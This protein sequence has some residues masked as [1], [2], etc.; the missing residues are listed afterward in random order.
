VGA[1]TAFAREIVAELVEYRELLRQIVIRDLLVRYKQTVMGVGWALFM[2]LLNTV[3]F[4]VVFMRVTTVETPVPYPLF[5]FSGLW[6][7]NFF[8]SALRFSVTSLTSNSNLV[9]KVYFPREILPLSTV[10]ISFVDFAVGSIVL[11][12]LMAWYG[13]TPGI[14]LLWLPVVVLIQMTF[15]LAVALVLAMGNLFYR[16]VRYLFEILIAA[17][18]FATSV[19]YPVDRV[20][21]VLGTLLRLNP[22]TSIVDSYRAVLLLDAPPPATLGVAALVAVVAL[23]GGWALFHRLEFEFAEHI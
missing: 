12:G 21:G 9:S 15:T 22:M 19:V 1:V 7:W 14:H 11:A 17:W 23:A 8:A 18:M 6:V 3:V 2:P 5:A 20:E 4:S 13:V 16:D 10:A